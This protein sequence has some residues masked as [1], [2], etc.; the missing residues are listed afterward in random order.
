M[1]LSL[2]TSGRRN[3]EP[4]HRRRQGQ[5]VAL[6]PAGRKMGSWVPMRSLVGTETGSAEKAEQT[7][8]DPVRQRCPLLIS[9]NQLL[10]GT[11]LL[12]QSEP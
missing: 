6:Q 1:A 8:E 12:S 2:W 3:Q 7:G 5:G 9:L 11:L 10:V 4:S